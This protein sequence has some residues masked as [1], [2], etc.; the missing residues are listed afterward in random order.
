MLIYGPPNRRISWKW[1]RQYSYFLMNIN[2]G[3][4]LQETSTATAH[5]QSFPSRQVHGNFS[6]SL[7]NK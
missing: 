3:P 1:R 6:I 5:V 7:V 2:E 4:Y